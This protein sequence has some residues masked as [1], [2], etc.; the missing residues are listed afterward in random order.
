M[1]LMVTWGMLIAACGSSG[2]PATSTGKTSSGKTYSSALDFAKCMRSHGVPK[3]PDPRSGG[4]GF[5]FDTSAI[6]PQSPAFQSA[7]QACRHLLP[8]GGPGSGR[9]S[10]QAHAQLLQIS[11]CM[12]QHGISAF[13][14]PQSG[15]PPSNPAGYSAIIGRG[16][17]FLAIPSS[18]DTNSPAFKHAATACKLGQQ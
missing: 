8:G 1:T 6:N 16:G 4:R 3:F 9:P 15:P 18:I 13:P 12:R 5:Q 11:T 2:H 10:A 17:Y 14:D 7:Q